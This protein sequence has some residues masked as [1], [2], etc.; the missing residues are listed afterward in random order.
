VQGK[1]ANT[2]FRSVVTIEQAHAGEKPKVEVVRDR[3]LV[4]S[5]H[6]T[7]TR[8]FT[9]REHIEAVALLG[10]LGCHEDIIKLVSVSARVKNTKR[11][12]RVKQFFGRV[13]ARDYLRRTV[14]CLRLTGAIHDM[15]AATVDKGKPPMLV[16]FA[17]GEG[18]VAIDSGV[19]EI[20]GSLHLDSELDKVAATTAVL[21]TGV[22]LLLRLRRYEL[23][24][25]KISLMCSAWNEHHGVA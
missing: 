4:V 3:I 1:F 5:G 22:G 18:R 15:A 21:G 16:R 7:Y 12:R 19:V 14:L 2:V 17:R 8:F 25:F 9:F 10:F 6:P 13:D 23:Y 20:L 24:P 11:M